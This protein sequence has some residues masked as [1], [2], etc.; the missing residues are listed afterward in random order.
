MEFLSC[1]YYDMI[2]DTFHKHNLTL[3]KVKEALI[4]RNL[5]KK[6]EIFGV[7]VRTN[8]FDSIRSIPL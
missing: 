3:E 5:E 8:Y 6:M 4:R 1:Q 2:Y 7:K